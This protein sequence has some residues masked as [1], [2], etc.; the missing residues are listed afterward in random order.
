MSELI[1]RLELKIDA[2]SA[3]L[4]EMKRQAAETQEHVAGVRA[5]G[6]HN[7]SAILDALKW[8]MDRHTTQR[9]VRQSVGCDSGS[10]DFVDGLVVG[11]VLFDD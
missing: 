1:E 8:L 5:A 6:R 11:A 9:E 7:A 4:A 10:P 2:M 3:E